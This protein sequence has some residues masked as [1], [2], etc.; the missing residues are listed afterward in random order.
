MAG[1]EAKDKKLYFVDLNELKINGYRCY[2]T[3][4]AD[5]ELICLLHDALN[6]R[7]QSQRIP[8]SATF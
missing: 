3:F 4:S 8:R 2:V 5:N 1:D 7:G 6:D